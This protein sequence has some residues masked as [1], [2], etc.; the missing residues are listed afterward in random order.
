M[1]AAEA[2]AG[3][4]LAPLAEGVFEFAHALGAPRVGAT[5][6]R[7]E[8][9]VAIRVQ[10]LALIGVASRDRLNVPKTVRV[11]ALG[12]RAILA[13][14]GAQEPLPRGLQLA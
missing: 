7:A 14:G 5:S 1:R 6:G 4:A 9:I 2:R 8:E 13:D 10:G 3:G 12:T 11:F